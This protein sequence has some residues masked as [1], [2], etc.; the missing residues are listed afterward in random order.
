MMSSAAA[1]PICSSV[2]MT[3][4]AF[5]SQS[6]GLS[7]SPCKQISRDPLG[8]LHSPARNAAP[9]RR[10]LSCSGSR[11][12]RW[13]PGPVRPSCPRARPSEPIAALDAIATSS[14]SMPWAAG[15]SQREVPA[16]EQHDLSRRCL[17][18][19]ENRPLRLW[20]P[21]NEAL[22]ARVME[23]DRLRLS[24]RPSSATISRSV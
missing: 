12:Q 14:I 10:R 20:I 4:I 8:Y 19:D 18:P 23:V 5:S 3:T 24:Q 1:S 6:P 15:F 17:Q 7:S 13:R 9:P 16:P 11:G 2:S 21:H 22:L